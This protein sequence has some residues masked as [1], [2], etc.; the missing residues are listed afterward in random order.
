MHSQRVTRYSLT[1][2][3]EEQYTQDNT[4]LHASANAIGHIASAI[5]QLITTDRALQELLKTQ[6]LTLNIISPTRMSVRY[7]A[8]DSRQSAPH[9]SESTERATPMNYLQQTM[10]ALAKT[11]DTEMIQLL[12]R[13]RA[14]LNVV[15]TPPEMEIYARYLLA[16][17]AQA[18]SAPATVAEQAVW[19]K[20]QD[21]HIATTLSQQ[22]VAGLATRK[23]AL[24]GG[25]GRN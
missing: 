16:P 7:E 11:G 20:I 21:D 9:L 10:L 14:R 4:Q 18:A 12:R 1:I 22:I 23:R 17:G 8:G 24:Q 25:F 3:F 13:F 19:S 5:E 15:L 2:A 6:N